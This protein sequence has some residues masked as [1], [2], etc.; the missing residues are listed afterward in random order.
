M[1]RTKLT[2]GWSDDNRK[3][4]FRAATA[5]GAVSKAPPKIGNRNLEQKGQ[6]QLIQNQEKSFT[7]KDVGGQTSWKGHHDNNVRH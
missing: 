6:K 2:R 7:K 1:A 5:S 3:Y 4:I